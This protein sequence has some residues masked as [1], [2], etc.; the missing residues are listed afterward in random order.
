MTFSSNRAFKVVSALSLFFCFASLI[1]T[2]TSH[3]GDDSASKPEHWVLFKL[4]SFERY[5]AFKNRSKNQKSLKLIKQKYRELFSQID[6]QFDG[7]TKQDTEF[8]NNIQKSNR[9]AS[10]M[11]QWH[12]KDNNSDL[13]LSKEELERFHLKASSQLIRTNR[14]FVARTDEQIKTTIDE[15]VKRDLQQDKNKDD[16]ISIQEALFDYKKEYED[17][18]NR[19]RGSV[20]YTHNTIPF[21]FDENGD[22]KISKQEYFQIVDKVL[23]GLDVDKD[24]YLSH[25]ESDTFKK[26]YKLLKDKQRQVSRRKRERL[27]EK[28]NLVKIAKILKSCGKPKVSAA[29][30][31]IYISSNQGAAITNIMFNNSSEAVKL[32]EVNIEAGELPLFIILKSYSGRIWK[33]TGATNRVESVW[34]ST[35]KMTSDYTPLAG[36]LGLPKEEVFFTNQKRCLPIYSKTNYKS[37]TKVKKMML[38]AFGKK[39]KKFVSD[40]IIG[41]V[42]L[43]SGKYD[44]N[45]QTF[46]KVKYKGSPESVNFWSANLINEN[47]HFISIDPKEVISKVKITQQKVIPGNLGLAKLVHEG[48]LEVLEKTRVTTIGK[49]TIIGTI[50]LDVPSSMKVKVGYRPAKFLITRSIN[51]NS[52]HFLNFKYELAH[53]VSLP[54]VIGKKEGS[55]YSRDL[56]KM[57]VI[58][59]TKLQ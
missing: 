40:S 24:G 46:G 36:V 21:S 57:I 5:G 28:E 3:A 18:F 9:L 43:P 20:R 1:T 29:A 38:F 41:S 55:V 54:V 58:Q 22:G 15:L 47:E 56:K 33:F 6:F 8:F 30:D 27:R 39:P 50:D 51:L 59:P 11:S 4:K 25:T 7:I 17:R 45:L 16:E 23:T 14:V 34:V 49:T 10:K 53:G 12:R 31:L 42:S 32:T 19:F 37:I 35:E 52:S 44:K 48:A 2:K 13:I 26:K